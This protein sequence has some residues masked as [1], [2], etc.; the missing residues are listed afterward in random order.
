MRRSLWLALS[1]ASVAVCAPVM[2]HAQ[3]PVRSDCLAHVTPTARLTF[4]D[5]T[6]RRW[7]HRYWAGICDGLSFFSC[8]SGKPHWNEAVT[9]IL[10]EAAP[11]RS[12]ELLAKACKIGLQSSSGPGI[13]SSFRYETW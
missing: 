7:Y 12:N 6:H 11:E 3:E 10:R 4:T 8:N 13:R 2:A 5:D 9:Q 1:L